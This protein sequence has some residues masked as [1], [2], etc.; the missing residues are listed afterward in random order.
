MHKL[1]LSRILGRSKDLDL[2]LNTKEAPLEDGTTVDLETLF[3]EEQQLDQLEGLCSVED[4]SWLISERC[5]I[6]ERWS[7][8]LPLFTKE[9]IEFCM[10]D[11]PQAQSK[12]NKLS[13]AQ[14]RVFDHLIT[15]N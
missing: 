1:V 14:H 10:D 4:Y 8:Y 15:M 11:V 9:E 2:L 5:W 7:Y 6:R 3:D 12:L 13:T